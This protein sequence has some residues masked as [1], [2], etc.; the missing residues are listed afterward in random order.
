MIFLDAGST[1]IKIWKDQLPEDLEP[2]A[3]DGNVA[4]LPPYPEIVKRFQ[5]DLYLSA[6]GRVRKVGNTYEITH[7]KYGRYRVRAKLAVNDAVA[8][9]YHAWDLSQ[10]RSMIAVVL[11][12]GAN[13]VYM[14]PWVVNEKILLKT[15]PEAGHMKFGEGKC[16]C[17]QVGC[18]ELYIS[19]KFFEKRKIDPRRA[20]KEVKEEFIHNLGRYVAS[21]IQFTLPNDVFVGG[22]LARLVP[23]DFPDI[24]EN[25]YPYY[26]DWS[27]DFYVILE[28]DANLLGLKYLAQDR[29]VSSPL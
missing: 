14:D 7:P 20:Q 23:P 29:V 24:V 17:G 13:A 18:A 4:L 5:G 15:N 27:F 26:F 9:A 12:G 8:F 11:G 3:I 21:L 25:F 2:M 28:R 16:P 6:A 10:R 1:S 22:G 19:S